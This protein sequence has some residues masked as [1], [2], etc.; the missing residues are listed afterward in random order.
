[1]VGSS[2]APK[3]L[4]LFL[5]CWMNHQKSK[6]HWYP[7]SFLSEDVKVRQCYFFKNKECI[8]KI[9]YLRIPKLLSNYILL[10]NFNLLEPIHKLQF[11]V[12]YP[13]STYLLILISFLHF[14]DNLR[15]VY[16]LCQKMLYGDG[17]NDYSTDFGLSGQNLHWKL[18]QQA[19]SFGSILAYSKTVA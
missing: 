19:P 4:I 15:E 11:N 13:V 2:L 3:W 5:F 12:R 7:I 6:F 18:G 17:D 1:M 16:D 9:Y 14:A 8:T 10:A